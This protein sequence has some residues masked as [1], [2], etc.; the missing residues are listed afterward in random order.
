MTYVITHGCCLDG[1]CI[2]VCPV[3]CIRPRPGDPDFSSTEQLYIDPETC[4]DCGACMDACPVDAIYSEWDLPGVLSEYLDVNGDYFADSSINPEPPV[5]VEASILPPGIG[6]LSVAVVGAGPAGCYLVEELTQIKGV[7]VSVFDRV[8]TPFGLIRFGVAPDHSN[9]KLIQNRFDAALRHPSVNCFFNVEVGRDIGVNDLLAAHHAVIW[10]GGIPEGRKLGIEGEDL[11]GFL[12][13]REFIQWVNGHPDQEGLQIDLQSHRVVVIGNGN[14]ALDIARVLVQPVDFLRATD[15]SATALSA[16][17]SSQVREVVVTARRGAEHAAFTEGEF[18][19][20][21][22]LDGARLRADAEEVRSCRPESRPR[23]SKLL[24]EAA[25][26]GLVTDRMRALT[27]RFGLQPKMANGLSR[28]ESVTF[29]HPDG[30]SELIET[31]LVVASVGHQGRPSVDLPFNEPEGA[32]WNRAGSVFDPTTGQAVTGV[33]CAGWIKRGPSGKIGTNRTDA[34]ETIATML[35]HAARGILVEPVEK[36][37]DFRRD[38]A[39]RLPGAVDYDG[40]RSIDRYERARGRDLG[41]PRV[42]ATDVAEMLG[43]VAPNLA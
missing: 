26:D 10:A 42:K 35:D 17:E 36:Y 43:A 11:T 6:Q 20:L 7:R 1:S 9:T 34:R 27:F 32:L 16:L 19:A 3:Q 2:P 15:I 29:G 37:L 25:K 5:L 24:Q 39:A 22:H 30:T 21:A 14:V 40:W 8:P 33:Y 38:V 41:R 23:S 4:I 31:G 12:T 18:A 28:V 13:A